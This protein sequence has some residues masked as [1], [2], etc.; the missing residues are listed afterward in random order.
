MIAKSGKSAKAFLALRNLFL[1]CAL[2]VPVLLAGADRAKNIPGIDP[3]PLATG[4][5]SPSTTKPDSQTGPN[6]NN[7]TNPQMNPA[8]PGYPKVRNLTVVPEPSEPF[9]AKISWDLYPDASTPVYVVRYSKPIANRAIL[10]E[11]YNLTSPPLAAGTQVFLNRD[12]PEGVYYYAVVTAF[13]LSRDG[14]LELKP[15]QNYTVVPFMVYRQDKSKPA[16]LQKPEATQSDRDPNL[17]P[18][19][20]YIKSLNALDTEKG[21]VLNW[22]G[23]PI[24]GIEYEVFRSAEPIDSAERIDRAVNLGKV[25]EGTPFFT[26]EGAVEGKRMYYGIAV[27]DAI[28][29][30]VYR[31][32]KYQASYIEHTHRRPK[33]EMRYDTFLPESLT[34]FLASGDTIQLIWIDPGPTIKE[35]RVFRNTMPITTAEILASSKELGTASPGSGGFRDSGLGAGTYYY[36]LLPITTSGELLSV[37]QPGR[38][39]TMFGV[40]LRAPRSDTGDTASDTKPD[41]K[42]D[43]T[44]PDDT[45][46]DGT[47]K[48]AISGFEIAPDGENVRLSWTVVPGAEATRL[49]AFRAKEP[50]NDPVALQSKAVLLGDF[51]VSDGMA[52]DRNPGVGDHYYSLAEYDPATKTYIAVYF[53]RR[54]LTI[55]ESRPSEDAAARLEKILSGAFTGARYAEA[56]EQLDAYLADADLTEEL[57]SKALFYLGV[58]KFRLQKYEEARDIFTDPVAQAHDRERALFW[59]RISLE[60]MKR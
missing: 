42:P 51:A 28:T 6:A 15:G 60:R 36:A 31:D 47:P 26:D 7:T 21:V 8:D 19:D 45:K 27:R 32:L 23:L 46:P 9:T 50:L 43:D 37:F 39:F 11:A 59:Y 48:S 13:E 4:D 53:S 14:R 54:P 20:F 30:K 22:P 10:L 56:E 34:A 44:K 29:G 1:L 33:L 18:E 57:R 55:T 3:L 38:T 24:R 5:G 52:I 17:K 16:D 35:Y 25:R 41:T 12:M 49:Q 58:V 2:L 40:S